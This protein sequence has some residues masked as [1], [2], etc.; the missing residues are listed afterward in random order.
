MHIK[1]LN[2]GT[3][4]TDGAVAYLLAD[5]DHQGLDRAEVTVLRGNPQL[6]A[7]V[8]DNLDFVHR[9]S[10]GVVSWAPEDQPTDADIS[11]VLDD[12][13]RVFTAGL[14]DPTRI[15]WTA[16]LHRESNGGCHVH[17]L[18]ARV[19]LAT[20]RSYNPAPPGWQKTFD[21]LRDAWNWEKGWA[22]PDDPLRARLYQPGHSA[23][24]EASVLRAGLEIEADPKA[25][26]TGYL[27]QRLEA[28]LIQNRQDIVQALEEAGLAVNRQGKDYLS[29]QDP[30]TGKKYRLK[31]ALYG[32]D[33]TLEACRELGQQ[34]EQQDRAGPTRD[35]EADEREAR[36]ARR[37][38]DAA[39]ERRAGYNHRRYRKAV[40]EDRE[41]VGA[42]VDHQ[43]GDGRGTDPGDADR[44][45]PVHELAMAAVAG[46]GEAAANDQS[47]AAKA[48]APVPRDPERR[49]VV[50]DRPPDPLQPDDRHRPRPKRRRRRN[51]TIEEQEA[52]DRIRD[53]FGASVAA[54]ESASGRLG[55]T[56][57]RYDRELS[58][59][60]KADGQLISALGGYRNDAQQLDDAI[61]RHG[62]RSASLGDAIKGLADAVE[63]RVRETVEKAVELA[64]RMARG[65][66]SGMGR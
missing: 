40:E 63:R 28:G 15:A 56:V 19:D 53:A 45:G 18:A 16:V 8:A 25:L 66:G 32:A 22:R 62:A 6:V 29:I 51:R 13:E 36:Q 4:S 65:L 31:G 61:G 58:G 1:F 9:Y 38:F 2:H 24:M 57:D 41:A 42:D 27:V 55:E 34:A 11:G 30:D 48:T 20:G 50:S 44:V 47:R 3:G 35:R 14:D 49:E 21:P 7:K 60:I 37:R 39:L 5:Q 17:L 12:V 59:V 43:P 23:L 52:H 54:L 26:V 33:F 64:R 46:A 10:S